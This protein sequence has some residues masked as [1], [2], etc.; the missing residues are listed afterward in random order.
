MKN[1]IRILL[2]DDHFIVRMG[3]STLLSSQSDFQVVAEAEDMEQALAAFD[4]D[5]PDITLLDVR[6]PGGSGL[7]A[8]VQI[9]SHEPKARVI[10]LS[11]FELEA[12]I[13]AAYDAGAAGYLN[14]A[15]QFAELAEAIR[16]V[17][18]GER[19]FPSTLRMF[20]AA[21]AEQKCLTPR[22]V[23]TLDLIR[24]GLSNKEIGHVLHISENTAK[25]HVKGVLHKLSVTDRAEAV[26]AAYD[27]GLLEVE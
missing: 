14:K 26:A 9:L 5:R 15:C 7:E 3:L 25:A 18:R 27:R 19:C 12:P 11:T 10:M 23:Q 4:Q 13:L 22:E 17:N 1:P 20:L 21:R 16:T 24:R 2:V 8:L 6:M